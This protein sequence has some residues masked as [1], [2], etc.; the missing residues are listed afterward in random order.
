MRS[1]HWPFTGWLSQTLSNTESN[2]YNDLLPAL[3][4]AYDATSK[5]VLRA[6]F[7]Q[8]TTEAQCQRLAQDLKD[9]HL[10]LSRLAGQR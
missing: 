3:N 4:I 7:S 8:E 10:K 6:S 9:V 5:L 1:Y 2:S